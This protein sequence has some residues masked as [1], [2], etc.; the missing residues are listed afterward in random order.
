[1]AVLGCGLHLTYAY[2]VVTPK[3]T[4]PS[5]QPLAV[6]HRSSWRVVTTFLTSF[7]QIS[8]WVP[9]LFLVVGEWKMLTL[10]SE[11][12][13]VHSSSLRIPPS[14][15]LHGGVAGVVLFFRFDSRLTV[16]SLFLPYAH[17]VI[18]ARG[19]L[20]CVFIIILQCWCLAFFSSL[21]AHPHESRKMHRH[22]DGWG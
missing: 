8:L 22:S 10:N 1:M 14:M 16:S 20:C 18:F 7:W 15:F 2:D 3:V 17:Q 11:G 4:M 21:P 6:T 5:V 12:R 19:S 9:R 13:M